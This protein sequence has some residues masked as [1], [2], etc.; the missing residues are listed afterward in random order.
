MDETPTPA[1]NQVSDNVKTSGE[2]L[3]GGRGAGGDCPDAPTG[4]G[5]DLKEPAE[6]K[7]E[8]VAARASPNSCGDLDPTIVTSI[9]AAVEEHE[10]TSVVVESGKQDDF[11]IFHCVSYLGAAI[12]QVCFMFMFIVGII[13]LHENFLTKGLGVTIDQLIFPGA[14]M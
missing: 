7:P 3:K 12:I 13:P 5:V 4:S 11:V 6:S 14:S 8:E 10:K 9:A 1:E 2:D